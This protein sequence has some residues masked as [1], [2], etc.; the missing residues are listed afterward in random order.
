MRKRFLLVAVAASLAMLA[1][2]VWARPAKRLDPGTQTCRVFTPGTI[3]EGRQLFKSVC[4]T[5]HSRGNAVGAPFM[6]SESKISRAWNR[7]FEKR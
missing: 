2:V 5:C 4:K 3:E 1:T 7:I 6:H